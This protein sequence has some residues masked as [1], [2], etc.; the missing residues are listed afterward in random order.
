[1]VKNKLFERLWVYSLLNTSPG[2]EKAMGPIL[3]LHSHRNDIFHDCLSSSLKNIVSSLVYTVLCGLSNI[4][5]K[6][7][8]LLI[9]RLPDQQGNSHSAETSPVHLEP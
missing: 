3:K 5:N 4:F 7:E 6:I 2:E 9:L 1:M 8:Q